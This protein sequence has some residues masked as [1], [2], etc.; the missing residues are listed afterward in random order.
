MEYV[1]EEGIFGL[2]EEKKET[3]KEKKENLL[4][5]EKLLSAWLF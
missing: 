1:P 2:F 5:K 4:N 3:E